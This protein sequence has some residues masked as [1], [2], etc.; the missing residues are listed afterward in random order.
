MGLTEEGEGESCRPKLDELIQ[1]QRSERAETAVSLYPADDEVSD[2][3]IPFLHRRILI[4]T[5][6]E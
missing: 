4:L 6:W 3:R 2:R 5:S 1:V